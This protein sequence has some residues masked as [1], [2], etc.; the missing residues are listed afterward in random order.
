MKR[1]TKNRIARMT[2]VFCAVLVA[3]VMLSGCVTRINPEPTVL[4]PVKYVYVR[5][6]DTI[7]V[8]GMDGEGFSVRLIGIDAPESVAPESYKK[9]VNTEKCRQSI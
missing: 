4:E 5:D 6:G 2:A 3:T 1:M 8:T 9:T 7:G